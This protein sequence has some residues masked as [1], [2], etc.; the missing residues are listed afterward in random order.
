MKEASMLTMTKLSLNDGGVSVLTQ[1][2]LCS[3]SFSFPWNI[4]VNHAT[5]RTHPIIIYSPS[6]PLGKFTFC[7]MLLK[8]CQVYP[9]CLCQGPL[10][11]TFELGN[12]QFSSEQTLGV[13]GSIAFLFKDC[14]FSQVQSMIWWL[15]SFSIESSWPACRSH[16]SKCE[17]IVLLLTDN[18]WT[19]QGHL[20][21]SEIW[22]SLGDIG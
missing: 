6:S 13:Y 11:Q 14:D 17:V 18:I 22:E 19:I 21:H 20:S 12:M 1:L 4:N 16:K 15:R 2:L 3:G 7:L 5:Q 10:S 9:C 8:C